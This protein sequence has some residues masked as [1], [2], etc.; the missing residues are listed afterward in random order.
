[1]ATFVE[2]SNKVV[3][4]ISDRQD[5]A[6]TMLAT[7]T[8]L[9]NEVREAIATAVS[10]LNDLNITFDAGSLTALLGATPTFDGMRPTSVSAQSLT[11]TPVT[12][13]PSIA[14]VGPVVGEVTIPGATPSGVVVS[15]SGFTAP[16]VAVPT[17]PPSAAVTVGVATS[18]RCV[19]PVVSDILSAAAAP[20]GSAAKSASVAT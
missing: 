19:A 1:M 7:T 10:S 2:L 8:G 15:T 12:F 9:I 17:V 16:A 5:V 18:T 6:I 4:S 3:S 13:E 14:D 20:G 11:F